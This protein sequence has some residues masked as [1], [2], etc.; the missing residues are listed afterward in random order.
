MTTPQQQVLPVMAPSTPLFHFIW[1]QGE[2]RVPESYRPLRDSW[3]RCNPD[4]NC[5]I[6]SEESIRALIDSTA[7]SF[8]PIF[9]SY[10]MIQK[11]DVAKYFIVFDQGGLYVDI[12]YRCYRNV[13]PLLAG[14]EVLIEPLWRRPGRLQELVFSLPKGALALNNALIYAARPGHPFFGYLIDELPRYAA[15][16]FFHVYFWHVLA[17]T[18]PVFLS[19]AAAEWNRR[20]PDAAVAPVDRGVLDTYGYH[21]SDISW[22]PLARSIMK[23]INVFAPRA[24]GERPDDPFPD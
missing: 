9:D 5:V 18:G 8:L 22:S 17:T 16:R 2:A 13:A 11:I 1:Y 24:R 10:S 12:D 6:W 3:L 14:R 7:P 19:R 20:N 23:V 21:S 4:A 15:R